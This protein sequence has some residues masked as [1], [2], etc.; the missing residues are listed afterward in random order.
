MCGFPVTDG[1]WRIEGFL[2]SG[3]TLLSPLTPGLSPFLNGSMYV[4]PPPLDSGPGLRA[5]RVDT[6]TTPIF[7]RPLHHNGGPC[8]K[9]PNHYTSFNIHTYCLDPRPTLHPQQ[10]LLTDK[11]SRTRPV[12]G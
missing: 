11:G 4:V 2:E 1:K 7:L 8:T 12:C 9:P 10:S 6:R 5:R 3:N